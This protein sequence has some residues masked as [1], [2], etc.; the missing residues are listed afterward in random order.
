M[1]H[2][3][4][5]VCTHGKS[6]FYL[7]R[8]SQ[9]A[10]VGT[11]GVLWTG[12]PCPSCSSE[13]EVQVNVDKKPTKHTVEEALKIGGCFYYVGQIKMLT[14]LYPLKTSGMYI[15][16]PQ[17]LEQPSDPVVPFWGEWLEADRFTG[18]WYGPISPPI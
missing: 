10:A 8:R 4:G 13:E 17:P 2:A 16:L 15:D 3:A 6:K 11:G 14:T 12:R 18:V 7:T 9:T 5:A 1:P